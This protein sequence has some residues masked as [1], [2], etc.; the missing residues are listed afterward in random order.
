[1]KIITSISD[2]TPLLPYPLL[3][4]VESMTAPVTE[5]ADLAT[6]FDYLRPVDGE[7][8]KSILTDPVSAK[9]GYLLWLAN[10]TG[11][12]LLT[13]ASGF[14]PWAAFDGFDWQDF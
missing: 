12:N 8:S 11:T 4:Y 3:R 9:A 10:V 13:A 2:N 5:I 1:M 7:E 6:D 14:T